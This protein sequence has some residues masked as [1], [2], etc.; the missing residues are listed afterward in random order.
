MVHS[1]QKMLVLLDSSI[2][3][4]PFSLFDLI[5]SQRY[6]LSKLLLTHERSILIGHFFSLTQYCNKV[7][8][9]GIHSINFVALTIT[10]RTNDVL[11]V[12]W[13]HISD[14]HLQIFVVFLPS[15]VVYSSI[16]K[17]RRIISSILYLCDFGWFQLRSGLL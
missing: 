4:F 17:T 13:R 15:L 12:C 2:D 10:N 16:N 1:L 7:F 8:S 14:C 5:Q 11:D 6:T 3:T 9:S